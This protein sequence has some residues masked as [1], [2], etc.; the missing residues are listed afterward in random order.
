MSDIENCDLQPDIAEQ[1]SCPSY[2]SGGGRLVQGLPDLLA[3]LRWIDELR[4][5]D[6]EYSIVDDVSRYQP[7][8]DL[9]EATVSDTLVYQH[10]SSISMTSWSGVNQ[11]VVGRLSF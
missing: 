4:K 1:V 5:Q 8:S 10:A 7:T 9:G 2:S 3:T 11:P 6:A